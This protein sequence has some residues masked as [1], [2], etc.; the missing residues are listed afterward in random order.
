MRLQAWFMPLRVCLLF[1]VLVRSSVDGQKAR[2]EKW[3][4][5]C[6]CSCLINT[7]K[8]ENC[9]I[10]EAFA[11]DKQRNIH[12]NSNFQ[13]LRIMRRGHL[14]CQWRAG[15]KKKRFNYFLLNLTCNGER[16]YVIDRKRIFPNRGLKHTL[17][18]DNL[19]SPN[20]S[21]TLRPNQK[22]ETKQN[23]SKTSKGLVI[24][25]SVG[26]S[27]M[28][29][30]V[31]FWTWFRCRRRRTKKKPDKKEEKS[32]GF[33]YIDEEEDSVPY[34]I[35]DLQTNISSDASGYTFLEARKP[36]EE[37]P[38]MKLQPTCKTNQNK[39]S[40]EDVHDQSLFE[41]IADDENDERSYQTLLP[42][43]CN[44]DS[45]DCVEETKDF[46]EIAD[47]PVYYMLEA[48]EEIS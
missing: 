29:A 13:T 15:N 5:E 2:L 31:V 36:E 32:D 48:K 27:L 45:K 17:S 39:K 21:T 38:Y 4:R 30:I 44:N 47:D 23:K 7:S 20:R 43:P 10:K 6:N 40:T 22:E 11:I 3:I 9:A 37:N 26:F 34:R 8:L 14:S 12:S 41:E 35:V 19:L 16:R 33:G 25:L 1:T 42:P 28:V 46:E 18:G 24:G